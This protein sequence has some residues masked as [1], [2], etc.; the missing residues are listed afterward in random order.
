MLETFQEKRGNADMVRRKILFTLLALCLMLTAC[1]ANDKSTTSGSS[2]NKT[3][4]SGSSG[5]SAGAKKPIELSFYYPVQVGGPVTAIIDRMA[6]EFTEENPD[7]IVKP[8][9]AGSYSDTKVKVQ[10]AVMSNTPP[11]VAV[12]LAT[13]LF[14]FLDMDA[15]IPLDEYVEKEGGE[16]FLNEFYPAWIENSQANG[17]T[18][19]I[20]FQRSTVVMYYNK[21][22]FREVG[23][24]PE[25][26]PQTWDELLEY[27]KKLT[28]DGRWGIELPSN[29]PTS[30]NWIFQ[31][32]AIQNG[33]TYDNLINADGTEAYFHTPENVEALTFWNDLIHTHKVMPEGIIEWGT[34]PSDFTEGK[35]AMIYHTTG[36]LTNIKN[37]AKFDFGVA[38]LPA[39][40]QLG[41]PTGGGNFYLFK[42]T[43][44]EKQDAAWEFI[45]FMTTPE[46]AAAWSKET[47]YVAIKPA[48]YETELMKEYV[49]EFP[50]VTVARDQLPYAKREI[51]T[52]NY[53][54][55]AKAL[56]DNM[57]AVLLGAM[58]PEEGLQK[59]QQEADEA[60]KTFKK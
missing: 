48:A 4:T 25:R 12:L 45:K 24:D 13:D 47:G 7:I 22:A 26:P 46:R 35:V 34:V 17:H 18:Y 6:A 1:G 59:A 49:Q 51:S 40:R 60:L 3:Q 2:E 33:T 29:G 55:V 38:M 54:R 28:K 37:N 9:Y 21:D 58:T 30:F 36:N 41:T 39:G 16:A 50:F 43:P 10:A 19:S 27:A 44:K 31:A 52:H 53:G 23:L 11:D 5:D 42:G 57:Q 14:D 8:I 56:N 32:F 20:P 15:I